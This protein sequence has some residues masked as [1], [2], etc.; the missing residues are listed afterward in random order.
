MEKNGCDARDFTCAYLKIIFYTMK[1]Q[2]NFWELIPLQPLG[3]T[4]QFDF[5]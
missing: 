4:T 2:F 5:S 1:I 3:K